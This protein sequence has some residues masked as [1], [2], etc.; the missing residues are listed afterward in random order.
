MDHALQARLAV[1]AQ[2]A[3]SPLSLVDAKPSNAH[4]RSS[5]HT[6]EWQR[7]DELATLLQAAKVVQPPSAAKAAKTLRPSAGQWMSA[8]VAVTRWVLG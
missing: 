2:V 4:D 6:D 3:K 5:D 1:A 7:A 8:S